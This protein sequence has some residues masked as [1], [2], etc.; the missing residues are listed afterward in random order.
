MENKIS[1]YNNKFVVPFFL[2][3]DDFE[4]NNA[5][6]SHGSSLL[7]IYYSFPTAPEFL[8][9]KLQNIFIA[10]L[11]KSK[12]LKKFGNDVCF[13]KLIDIFNDLEKNG[14]EIGTNSEK[15]TIYFCL[16][17]IIADN[18]ALN[19]ILGFSRSF[20]SKYFCRV[21]RMPNKDT[22]FVPEEDISLL[23]NR[24]NYEEDII[25]ANTENAGIAQN[26]V[27]NRINNYHVVDNM[28]ADLLHDVFEGILKYDI[29]HIIL[30][31]IKNNT[32]DLE[33]LNIRKEN[34][35]YGE[36]ENG[37]KSPPIQIHHLKSFA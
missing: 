21:C 14:I 26:S 23:R 2:Y 15:R 29:C 8:K 7:G 30:C 9:F 18:L 6:G 17:L 20:S 12:D 28:Y 32:F 22:K 5:F 19:N 24:V 10:A 25:L 11:F 33:L 1:Q 3:F 31:F 16:G 35:Q 27:F 34:F 36:T 4:I 13:F 37:N